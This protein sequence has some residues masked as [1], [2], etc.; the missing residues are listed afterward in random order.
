MMTVPTR[1][2]TSFRHRFGLIL[3][4]T[5]TSMEHDLWRIIFA[6]QG[7]GALRGVGLHTT[8]VMTPSPSL[9]TNADRL[10]YGEQFLGGLEAAVEL[11]LLAEPHS[12]IL[13][14]SLEHVVAGLESVADPVR[15]V[16]ERSRLHCAA[17]HEAAADALDR[18]GARRIGILSPFDAD[19]AASARRLFEELGYDVVASFGFACPDARHIA[20]VPEWAKER[21][22]LEELAVDDHRLDAVV[23]CGTNMSIL[24]VQERL[25]PMIGIPIL[26]VNVVTFWHALR[27]HGIMEPLE[28]G[29]R[30]LR[31][32]ATTP[33][34]KPR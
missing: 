15:R 5:N 26:G 25:E 2:A 33:M 20:R 23:Q 12:L 27:S 18:F 4:A 28:G 14:M 29:G 31:E 19:G 11:A 8:A 21:A 16:R 9:R 30:L 22:I 34:E 6:N 17:W 10:H 32:A 1:D 3:P 7:R 24:A 13:G